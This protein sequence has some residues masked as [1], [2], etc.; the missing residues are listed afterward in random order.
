MSTKYNIEEL[1]EK[2]KNCLTEERY[3]HSLGTME[4]AVNLALKFGCNEEKARVAGLMHDCAK[5][6]SDE[7]FLTYE[8]LLEDFEKPSKKTWHAPVG[9]Y[10]AKTVYGIDDE[11]I[12]SAIR[13][14]TVGKKD[15]T[16]LEKIIFLADKTECKTREPEI[17]EPIEEVLNETGSLDAALLKCFKMTVKSLLKRRLPISF[18]TID[19]YNEI[20]KKM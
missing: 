15:M 12:L 14:H 3:L 10:I 1:K 17:R 18:Q 6:L 7:E 8:N 2:L 5:C 4:Q 13:W 16:C 9:A 19:V 11:E 20:L